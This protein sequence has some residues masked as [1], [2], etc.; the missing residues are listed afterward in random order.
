[1][2]WNP[3]STRITGYGVDAANDWN[4]VVESLAFLEEVA[5]VEFTSDVSVTG[6]GDVEIVSAGAVTFEA[7]PHLIEFQ[8]ARA[9]AG[10]AGGLNI[11]LF[12]STTNLGLLG[13]VGTGVGENLYRTRRLTPTA[14]SHTYRVMGKNLVSQTSTVRAGV[15]GADVNLPGYIRITRI[16]T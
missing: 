2:P 8:S 6:T 4:P 16:P 9:L 7:V 12:D 15:G 14:A 5:Y 13:A 10:G 3:P 1:M 11:L